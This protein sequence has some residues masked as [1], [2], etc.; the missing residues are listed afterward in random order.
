[1]FINNQS[2]SKILEFDLRLD[3]PNFG[4]IPKIVAQLFMVTKSFL[5]KILI[6]QHIA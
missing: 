4:S 6:T 3:I 2:V 5:P 1:M